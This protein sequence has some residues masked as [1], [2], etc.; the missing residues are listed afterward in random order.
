MSKDLPFPDRLKTLIC[1]HRRSL[2]TCIL[3]TA[4]ICDGRTQSISG[5][6]VDENNKPVPF[7]NILIQETGGGASAD[8]QGRYYLTIDPGVYNLIISSVGYRATRA[9]VV[10]RD[11]PVTH[12][13]R[14]TSSAV[15]LEQIE[16]RVRRR[17]PAYEIMQKAI[18][19]KDHYLSQV[20]SSRT[21]IYLRASEQMEVNNKAKEDDEA[22][23]LKAGEPPPDPFAEARKKEEARLA[24][25]N[26]VEMELVLNFRHPNQ[27]KEERTAF[28][29][30][31]SRS[32]LFIPIFHQTDFNFYHNLVDLKGISE[33][34]MIS[35]LSRTAILSYRFKLEQI[36]KEGRQTVYKIRVTPRKSGDATAK[37]FVFINDS[38][39]N[40]NRLQLTLHKGGL[41]FYDDFTISQSYREV[42]E[43]LWIPQRQEFSYQTRFG[44][45]LFKGITLL[46]YSDFENDCEFAP[47]FFGNEVAIT[48]SEAYKRDSSYWKSA[49]PEPLEGD[50]KKV[51]EYR[52]SLEAVRTSKKYLDSL[53]TAFNKVTLGEVLYHGIGFRSEEK[54][55]FVRLSPLI[56]LVDFSVV[57]GWRIGPN[58]GYF[59]RF[60][61]ERIIWTGGALRIGLKNQDWQGNANF[62]TRYNPFRQG[63]VAFKL[64]RE[65]SSINSFD[66][67]LNQLRISNYIMRD[68]WDF[69]HRIELFNGF[70]ISTDVGFSNRK[71][72]EDY[73]ATSIINEVID[74]VEPIK[75]EGY[76]ALITNLRLAYTPQ[77]KYMREPFQKVVLGSKYPTFLFNHKKGWDDILDSDIDFDY[78]DVGIDH[79]LL[80]GTLGNSRYT[81]TAGKFVNAE[82]LR[83]VDLKRFRQSDPYLYSNP[84]HSFQLLDTSLVATDL[85]LEAHY[86]HHFNGA[87]INNIPLVKKLKIRTVAG[88]GFMWISESNFRHEEIFGGIERIFK[89]G[90]RRRLKIGLYGVLGQSNYFPPKTD[91]K[92]S[93]DIID[94][95]KRDWSY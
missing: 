57:G 48:T 49:R 72:I 62:R 60:K 5:F 33:I 88:A 65:F 93:F 28:K 25:I 83:Y 22:E 2:L 84:M 71:S 50:Q 74:E 85:F 3:F 95:W 55:S 81:F 58:A 63:E 40:I 36:L 1:L 92:I 31:G 47:R 41:R 39:W 77:Q 76:Q 86:I 17:D 19:R 27:F 26:L 8:D 34:P 11:S 70:Y 61:N 13:F 53:E 4:V 29:S 87:M 20:K 51:I 45:K 91:W 37:G 21:K 94:T 24:K 44:R 30:Y 80:L 9:Q 90:A 10:V 82:D 7:A 68:Y 75:F 69:F 78:I 89:L 32:G 12:D 42:D 43:G 73:D 14:L 66:A 18:D 15:E 23:S 54:K 52:D 35:P 64:G 79:S 56:G 46:A 38:T 6:I 16:I 67:Y 59:K